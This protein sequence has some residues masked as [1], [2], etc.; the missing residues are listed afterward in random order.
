MR[1]GILG[2]L[3]VRDETGRAVPVR[4]ARLRALLI[5]LALDPGRPVSADRLLDDLWDGDPPGGNAL[6]AV[7]SRLRAA[8]GRDLVEHGPTG[9]RLA[10]DPSAVDAVAFEHAVATARADPDPR[11][12][13][14]SLGAALDLWRGP[15]LA[16]VAG[17]AF[18]APAITRLE[19]AR[20]T[21]VEDRADADLALGAGA[22]LAAELEPLV[23][24]HPLRERLR[25]LLMR[26]LAAAGRP[27]DAL[28]VF[29]DGRDVLAD[30]LGTDPSPELTAVHLALLRREPAPAP[31]R[32]TNLPA[33][34]TTFVGRESETERVRKLVRESRLVTLTGP[35]G[36][37]K[38]RLSAEAAAGLLDD[39]PD[40]VWFVPLASVS[41][42]RDIPAA[43]LTALGV[44]E[45]LLLS[46]NRAP[47]PPLDRLA[48]V[49]TG[50]D[51]V[52]V[53]D[54]CEHLVDAVATVVDRVLGAA[55]AVR[56][57]ATSREP[58][59]ITGEALC[60]VPSLPLP[61][62]DAG[63]ADALAHASV[64][65]FADRAAAVRPG[66]EVDAATAPDVV[67]ICRA[68]DG[69]PLA[70]ELA[71][72][73]L[74][75]LTPAQVA[76]RLDDRFRLLTAG[77]RTALPRHRTLRAVV[78]WSWDLLDD[79]ERT[80]LRR[81]SV[82][83]GGAT[84][85]AAGAVCGDGDAT[86]LIDVVAALVEK[87]LVMAD[88]DTEVRYRLLETV[89]VYAAERLAD[90]GEERAVRDRH[91]AWVAAFAAR[92]EP[93]LRRAEQL[94][95]ADRLAAER[96]N[97]AAAL[98]HCVDVRDV[99]CAVRL[100]GSLVWFWFMR[101]LEREAGG[102]ALEVDAIAGDTA[103]PGLAE[104]FAIMKFSA[105]L[106]SEMLDSEGPTP[107][108]LRI[109]LNDALR[110]VPPE[111]AHPGLVVVRALSCLFSGDYALCGERLA[112]IADHPDPW[113]QG[114]VRLGTAFLAA[115]D[116]DIATAEVHAEAGHA[117]FAGLGDRV[118]MIIGRTALMRLA[119]ARGDLDT[120]LRHGE[121]AHAHAVTGVSPE[122]GASVLVE[123]GKVR[124][125]AGDIAGAERDL[126]LGIVQS[127]R[128]GEFSEAAN[129][130]VGLSDIARRAG[131]LA[132][133]RV[134][135]EHAFGLVEQR[136]F[137]PDFGSTAVSVL[138]RLATLAA[139]EGD[140]EAADHWHARAFARLD[141]DIMIGN[142]GVAAVL[143]GL[144]LHRAVRGDA[145][146][147]AELLGAA[148][149]LNGYRDAYNDD[150]L[151]AEDAARSALGDASYEAAH[152]RGRALS[153]EEIRALR[154]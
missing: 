136:M 124:A 40:G 137:R 102:W 50:R 80:V 121:R 68:L 44:H 125:Y 61:P 151:A 75:S 147:A 21:A 133:A 82:F 103:P 48:E 6:Q 7:V 97:C 13:A 11:R 91:A 146:R 143:C 131:D 46:E 3:D 4:G 58:L 65:L 148:Q 144:A 118:G 51:A 96:D 28:S 23:A 84:P 33:R 94:R 24:A 34:F 129:G 22:G 112:A 43:V 1:I 30:R 120:A 37:G 39:T 98:R 66:F 36:A 114:A 99:P 32:R 135:L 106:V 141:G 105:R 77:S 85:D 89:R 132:A 74:R 31:A 45:S 128:V 70:I 41:D 140:T 69:I 38:T 26:A 42:G 95:W 115:N 15:A 17:A 59:G 29:A 71:A 154:A 12:R 2:T 53:L 150:L 122:Q 83:A 92:A 111:P 35:G 52:L 109:A 8:A 101:D 57:L 113:V 90:A 127:E 10:L 63:P 5:R 81:L 142:Q 64:R 100:V 72:A 9:Y 149:A 130:Y 126:R 107:G 16:D 62:E 116:G 145:V 54:N 47:I 93:E 88:G 67:R 108:S 87:S 18:A 134:P 60:P 110:V 139:L 79:A 117:I 25:G 76:E 56:V 152:A 27:A 78:D 73:R 123:T 20:L 55:P 119:L 153:R 49:L 14:A 104:E 19:E 86:D 138:S